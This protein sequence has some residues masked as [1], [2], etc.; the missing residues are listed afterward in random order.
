MSNELIRETAA[1]LRGVSFVPKTE[2][3]NAIAVKELDGTVLWYEIDIGA[4]EDSEHQTRDYLFMP[5]LIFTVIDDDGGE[6]ID[7]Q[8][9]P[10]WAQLIFKFK[11]KTYSAAYFEIPLDKAQTINITMETNRQLI[12]HPLKNTYHLSLDNTR[13]GDWVY[14]Q[15]CL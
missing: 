11:G 7:F 1:R 8:T 4:F 15:N 5:R 3:Q 9:S 2:L 13:N 10:G 14:G 6:R 12:R